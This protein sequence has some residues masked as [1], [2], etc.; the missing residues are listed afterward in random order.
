MYDIKQLRQQIKSEIG[1]DYS[2]EELTQRF[3]KQLFNSPK[4]SASTNPADSQF[5]T[6]ATDDQFK[7]FAS[8]HPDRDPSFL[9]E[10]YNEV[11][12][13]LAAGAPS[14]RGKP[15]RI[16][17]LESLGRERVKTR[18]EAESPLWRR[19]IADP[20]IAL[21]GKG[22][23]GAGE[24]LVGLADIVSGGQAG[25]V[26]DKTGYDPKATKAFFE[27]LQSP[28]QRAANANVRDAKGVWNTLKAAVTNPT[29][30]SDTVLESIPSMVGGFGIRGAVMKAA[31]KISGVLAAA[32]G[33]GAVT[34]G[35]SAEAI[36]QETDT[37]DLSLKQ[38]GLAVGS[39]LVTALLGY[40]GGKLANQLG[41]GD[42]DQLFMG[43]EIE[44]GAKK[45]IMRRA[46]E[47]ALSEGVFE[48]LPQ[49]VQEQMAQNLATEKP[50]MEGVDN[51][52]V[53]GALSGAVMGGGMNIMQPKAAPGAM[54]KDQNA[55]PSINDPNKPPIIQQPVTNADLARQTVE[56]G[57]QELRKPAPV[58][59]EQRADDIIGSAMA[60]PDAYTGEDLESAAY[61]L[62]N[63]KADTN[64]PAT[65]EKTFQAT[66]RPSTAKEAG[67]VFGFQQPPAEE[68]RLQREEDLNKTFEALPVSKEEADYALQRV[69]V[70][71]KKRKRTER[72]IAKT[73][74][75][76]ERKKA[77][78]ILANYDQKLGKLNSIL[79]RAEQEETARVTAQRQEKIDRVYPAEMRPAFEIMRQEV[80][81]STGPTKGQDEATGKRFNVGS[82]RPSYFQDMNLKR[83]KEKKEEISA[84]NLE[85]ILNKV[86]SGES[87][88]HRQRDMYR[89]MTEAAGWI[90]SNHDEMLSADDAD[91]LEK[92]G[93]EPMGGRKVAVGDIEPGDQFVGKIGD[94]GEDTFT[95]K[96][97]DAEGNAIIEDGVTVHVDPFE[98]ARVEG[99]KKGAVK[100]KDLVDD[101]VDIDAELEAWRN[102]R[103][104]KVEAADVIDTGKTRTVKDIQAKADDLKNSLPVIDTDGVKKTQRDIRKTMLRDGALSK[105]DTSSLDNVFDDNFTDYDKTR[106]EIEARNNT[107][108]ASA[109]PEMGTDSAPTGV[110]SEP[111]K[112]VHDHSSTQVNLPEKEAEEIKQFALKIPESEIY[113]DPND[114]SYGRETQ[115]HVT[116]RYGMDTVDPKEIAPAFEGLG[117][118]KAKMGKVS[119]FET[120]K[121]DVVKVDIE[122]PDLHS[123]N[124]KVGDTVELPGETFKDY[125]PHATI[126]YVKKGE[127]KKYVGDKSFEGKEITVDK[128]SLEAKD[129]KSH[130]FKLQAQA[131]GQAQGQKQVQNQPADAGKG[132]DVQGLGVAEVGQTPAQEDRQP[133]GRAFIAGK[134]LNIFSARDIGKG[135][136]A[137]KV[138]VEIRHK[139]EWRK[140]K[141]AKDAIVLSQKEAE[142]GEAGTKIET[143][144]AR[145][146][147]IKNSLA[148]GE[149]ILKSG[150]TATGRKMSPEQ[151][152][153]VRRSVDNSKAKI[154]E[155]VDASPRMQQTK[156]SPAATIDKKYVWL[157][158]PKGKKHTPEDIALHNTKV[159]ILQKLWDEDA[160]S[161]DL[162]W[163]TRGDSIDDINAYDLESGLEKIGDRR[164]VS[165]IYQDHIDNE[166]SEFDE[167][168]PDLDLFEYAKKAK[169]VT[170][171]IR[172][173]G[174]VLPDGTLLDFSG[175]RYG[176]QPGERAEDHR[177]LG[178]PLEGNISGTDAMVAFQK[179]GAVRIDA[180]SH[181]AD[182]ETMPTPAQIA[183]IEKIL[184]RDGYVDLSDGKRRASLENNNTRKTIGL[185][186]RFYSG[187]NIESQVVFQKNQPQSQAATDA[188]N[189]MALEVL[190]KAGSV[191]TQFLNDAEFDSVL[192]QYLKAQG[193]RWQKDT[194]K[195]DISTGKNPDSLSGGDPEEMRLEEKRVRAKA[196]DIENKLRE[197]YG[198]DERGGFRTYLWAGDPLLEEQKRLYKIAS[199]LYEKAIH[200]EDDQYKNNA[201]R[202]D[203][204]SIFFNEA[205]G[206]IEKGDFDY[207]GVRVNSKNPKTGKYPKIKIGSKA[208][209]SYYQPDGVTT[210]KSHGTS[211][212]HIPS[213]DQ[214][215]AAFYNL[216]KYMDRGESKIVL[217]GSNYAR[218]GND[219]DEIEMGDATILAVY[220]DNVSPNPSSAPGQV[221]D[222]TRN[223]QSADTLVSAFYS[224]MTK[225]IFVRRSA[226]KKDTIFHEYTHAAIIQLMKD[227]PG[228]HRKG[229][230]LTK[231]TPYYDQA[232]A[233]GYGVN[234]AGKLV[235]M[236]AALEEALVQ[237]IGERGAQIQDVA[238]KNR[239]SMW[240]RRLFHKVRGVMRKLTGRE[241]TFEEFT[242]SFAWGM[243]EGRYRTGEGGNA[244]GRSFYQMQQAA[245][246]WFSQM[247]KTLE[248]KLPGKINANM[249]IAQLDAWA[250][251]GE[252]KADELEW[253]GI[254]DWLKGQKD[255]KVTKAEVLEWLAG[256]NVKVEEVVLGKSVEHEYA[257]FKNEGEGTHTYRDDST[258]EI[259]GIITKSENGYLAKRKVDGRYYE[260][261]LFDDLNSA[262][263]SVAESVSEDDKNETHFSQ[264]QTFNGENYREV[265]L[266]VPGTKPGISFEEWNKNRASWDK[267]P[268]TRAEYLKNNP[269]GINWQDG[270]SQ[271]SDIQ[272]PAVRI[273]MSEKEIDGKRYIAV[274]EI[275][276]PQKGE[277][278]K[279]PEFMRKPD[280]WGKL[281]FRWLARYAAENGVDGILWTPGSVQADRY[282]LSKQVSMIEWSIGREPGLYNIEAVPRGETG[283]PDTLI[284]T[285]LS[286]NEVSE[287]VGKEL[288]EKI[289]AQESEGETFGS[290]SGLDLKVGGE[291]LKNL[292]DRTLPAIANGL[293]NKAAWGGAKVGE[294]EV[295]DNGHAIK[296]DT[297]DLNIGRIDQGQFE[298]RKLQ[299]RKGPYI[300]APM[301]PITPEMRAK[302]LRE[303]MPLFQEKPV[304]S[305]A[306]RFF[307]EEPE[308]KG[309]PKITKSNLLNDAKETILEI[310]KKHGLN[311]DLK[312]RLTYNFINSNDPIKVIQGYFNINDEN[313]DAHAIESL[314][315]K[316]ESGRIKEFR[317]E[318]IQ[319]LVDRMAKADISFDQLDEYRH[320]KHAPEANE[321]LELINA[322]RTLEGLISLKPDGDKTANK[323]KAEMRAIAQAATDAKKLNKKYQDIL[324]AD[325][326]DFDTLEVQ[327]EYLD[328]LNRQTA[329]I[330]AEQK[331]LDDWD[332]RKVRLAGITNEEAAE[333]ITKYKDNAEIESLRKAFAQIDDN[334]LTILERS[335]E[336]SQSSAAA[337]REAYQFYAPLY[338]EGKDGKL[339]TG[340]KLGPLGTPVKVRAGSTRA[341]ADISAHTIANFEN[342]ISRS[343]K[344][345]TGRTIYDL[346]K[347]TATP[348][349]SVWWVEED[350]RKPAYD[351]DGN[352]VEYPDMV[353]PADGFFVKVGGKRHLIKVNVENPTM[354]RFLDSLKSAPEQNSL[355]R[356]LSAVNR[357]LAAV[358]TS[359]S[360]EFMFTNL[361]KDLQTA[362]I[363]LEDTELK[364]L[365]KTV[366]KQL[367]SAIKG[368]WNAEHKNST[369]GMSKWYRDFEQSGGKVGWSGGY[370]EIK[371]ISKR[372]KSELDMSQGGRKYRRYAKAAFAAIES[373]NTAIENGVRLSV[374]KSMVEMGYSKQKAATVAS[375]LTV[376]FT[377]KGKQG[378]TLNAL[379]LFANAGIQGNVRMINAMAHSKRVQKIVG[380]IIAG[381][382]VMNMLGVMMGGDDDDDGMSNYDKLRIADPGIFE[383]NIVIMT[384]K[385]SHIKIP[386]P[387]GYNAFYNLGHEIGNATYK[388]MSGETYDATDGAGR[389]LSGFANSFN[390]LSSATLLQAIAPT[391]ADPLAYIGENKMWHG[392]P[393]M[394][395]KNTF[396]KTPKPDSERYFKS[397][398]A[399]SKAIAS[400][401]NTI[402]GGDKVE[403][404][405]IDVSPETLDMWYD[406]VTGSAGRFVADA[407]ALPVADDV[408]KVPF[409]RRFVGGKSDYIDSEIYNDKLTDVLTLKEKIKEG[410]P[411]K[412]RKRGLIPLAD[413]IE[414]KLRRLRKAKK[415]I[416]ATGGS[417]DSIENSILLLQK[418]FVR[419]YEKY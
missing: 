186:K 407:L 78:G 263:I 125:Q 9:Q 140:V 331:Y 397:V 394:P 202:N 412:D 406:T 93:F 156:T 85:T 33:E 289:K 154:G 340:R 117:P 161:E 15:I 414:K 240:L 244:E 257:S 171:N 134:Q 260:L 127:G 50:I 123:V 228:F 130:E 339:S 357:V 313:L 128:I 214:I 347:K 138:E 206:L 68:Q 362:S 379:Y 322:K 182:L 321:R 361:V 325:M 10:G 71:S 32:L 273:R 79:D 290:F 230:N 353:E 307:A 197:K 133:V 97:F 296:E 205:K 221:R 83:K 396:D 342:A 234:K 391:I 377:K 279:Q 38:T 191:E 282:D 149:M 200:I 387:W 185:I 152:A 212:I 22:V 271:Y 42:I 262:E 261:G 105:P 35:G 59:P 270:H 272:N 146:Q 358:N 158:R 209:P 337:M 402:T 309:A 338:R 159:E 139:G 27:E 199:D 418:R 411:V 103:T 217:L 348:D 376:D 24:T 275:Q 329:G 222:N 254:K 392:G 75:P 207:Y 147:E 110:T 286:I 36:R 145:V 90:N 258:D 246:K 122:S 253:S 241:M 198:K 400:A 274:E 51:A 196:Y 360:P 248:A 243:R 163:A 3:G 349:K 249:L 94:S 343:L 250:K 350:P 404:G 218:G 304:K 19:A 384:G 335:G 386:M 355:V 225:K 82:E 62:L 148:E 276:P 52:A 54:D 332:Y 113:S 16:D 245:A 365:Q 220:D 306:D 287:F 381:G 43:Q 56:A 299:Q 66:G 398:S 294:I 326:D 180:N 1:V 136:N 264:Y 380:G 298:E 293:F 410:M 215:E 283:A 341:V 20:A 169:G 70:L 84:A 211:A 232:I 316:K 21:A 101:S 292:Y 190:Q 195:G 395:D 107:P 46:V 73:T 226:A 219:F 216:S 49:S 314:R 255:G 364:G 354:V 346:V 383:R 399:P 174:Y 4:P 370:E 26:L 320:A 267:G 312:E 266:T 176:G 277:Q 118:V 305:F 327:Q 119:I 213:E 168:K 39:G 23:V 235:D 284:K 317:R 58:T 344:A 371:D 336:L 187:E 319:P 256:N 153:A 238:L 28:A 208:K 2:D 91:H 184:G 141:V 109:V 65:Q 334:R 137:G 102:E 18:T 345:E 173:A 295:P 92:N 11:K 89:S 268:G 157:E 47:G 6:T 151:L 372:L 74:D 132:N 124:K 194:G 57:L 302:A 98:M 108:D 330:D 405:L 356:G 288:S 378:G 366:L 87:L 14:W 351:K 401:L 223:Q 409:V 291:G 60:D 419:A 231:G 178:I 5:R 328:L 179:A 80:L 126:A 111:V 227:N 31:P 175:K 115:P 368:I 53:M 150:K 12:D 34:A 44:E 310:A 323:L 311:Q 390:P 120:D 300:T 81:G 333:I 17:E 285:G 210:N 129:G 160:F 303:G 162:L 177:Q 155:E 61:G 369:E 308:P 112:K 236:N 121:Y 237:A 63:G 252:Y 170:R 242:E 265:F 88:T 69:S 403:S 388:A 259:L 55:I 233:N 375:G 269:G 189:R 64:Q 165:E 114:D 281:A 201:E 99:L 417:A 181:M 359:L 142:R 389:V 86:E 25:K 7:A 239:F 41:I 76:V 188:W 96:G 40:M 37:R 8:Q 408:K 67:M 301:F 203:K 131:P 100:A 48:E 324:N 367:P 72:F 363:H 172:E 167:F 116:V 30:I 164:Y 385:N 413:T 29:A 278:E 352:I 104:K 135:R 204:E 183:I 144:P 374:Y 45:N 251:K 106:A 318:V 416:E 143:D 13:R 224:P 280:Y 192:G 315:G 229:L 95:H 166:D 193:T 415:R 297:F 373:A 382:F 393:M 77:E 247:E